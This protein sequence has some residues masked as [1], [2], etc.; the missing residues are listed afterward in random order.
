MPTFT[1]PIHLMQH[2]VTIQRRGEQQGQR[3]GGRPDWQTI[4]TAVPCRIEMQ[5][6]RRALATEHG[7]ELRFD[8]RAFFPGGVDLAPSDDEGV[9]DRIIVEAAGHLATGTTFSVLHVANI[10]GDSGPLSHFDVTL[11]KYRSA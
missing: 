11:R 2:R 10:A 7:N 3:F 5:P 8:A 6:A 4:A 1:G 9:A